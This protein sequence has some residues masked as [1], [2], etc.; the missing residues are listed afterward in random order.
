MQRIS[1]AEKFEGFYFAIL[2]TWLTK[3]DKSVQRLAKEREEKEQG[4][5]LI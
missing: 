5:D 2:W 4:S 3:V 1:T